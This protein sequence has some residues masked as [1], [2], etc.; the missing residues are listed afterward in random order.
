M[1]SFFTSLAHHHRYISLHRCD[2]RQVSTKRKKE[3][4]QLILIMKEN[5]VLLSFYSYFVMP[6][7]N[8]YLM[9]YTYSYKSR[10]NFHNRV[11]DTRGLCFGHIYS[12]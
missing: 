9:T 10:I 3:A 6:I 12:T 2:S 8:I 11:G 4:S 7:E 1:R 5:V